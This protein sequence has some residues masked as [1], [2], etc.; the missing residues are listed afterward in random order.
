MR[1]KKMQRGSLLIDA[2]LFLGVLGFTFVGIS[3]LTKDWEDGHRGAA[4]ASWWLDQRGYAKRYLNAYAS[5]FAEIIDARPGTVLTAK[6][7][8]TS[9]MNSLPAS[10]KARQG[11]QAAA[12]HPLN[13]SVYG[14]DVVLYIYKTNADDMLHGMLM[15]EGGMPWRIS[16]AA[17][18]KKALNRYMNAANKARGVTESAIVGKRN[19][20][21]PTAD[22][23]IYGLREEWSLR[24]ADVGLGNMASSKQ[25]GQLAMPMEVDL[26]EKT[27]NTLYRDEVADHPELNAMNTDLH[28]NGWEINNVGTIT[29]SNAPSIVGG[30]G[31]LGTVPAGGNGLVL[32]P[33]RK[34]GNIS[35]AT[36]GTHKVATSAQTTCEAD[37]GKPDGFIFTVNNAAPTNSSSDPRD[38]N[39]LYVCMGGRARQISD[40]GNSSMVKDITMVT[41]RAVI[42]KPLCP[43]GTVPQ[44]YIA[45][46]NIARAKEVPAISAIRTRVENTTLSG[47]PAW[48]VR[49]QLKTVEDGAST[50][51]FVEEGVPW[52]SLG[53]GSTPKPEGFNET[54]ALGSSYTNAM[55]FSMCVRTAGR[56]AA[57]SSYPNNIRT[58][59]PNNTTTTN[60]KNST[61]G[62]ND[63]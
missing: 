13:K 49:L 60:W 16:A 10:H 4:L 9:G 34:N 20:G 36:I 59:T 39:G 15:S 53:G 2:I 43:E 61:N 24:L 52:S 21:L 37:G 40:S 25:A 58:D 47:A 31:E 62:G 28:M 17:E 57:D 42:R 26:A 48:K 27:S 23:N 7:T 3:S 11:L 12:G 32:D 8:T 46:V 44:I 14:Q 5:D 35:V 33:I 38:A 22:G 45:P 19:N 55:A 50:N 18:K 56:S 41:S 30:T 1:K 51:F 63:R 54:G 29:I 6:S